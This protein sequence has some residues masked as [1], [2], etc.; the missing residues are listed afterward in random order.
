MSLGI[1]GTEMHGA[2]P[3]LHPLRILQK[4]NV[5]KKCYFCSI[6]GNHYWITSRDQTLQKKKSEILIII[7][8]T[9]MN[10]VRKLSNTATFVVHDSHSLVNSTRFTLCIITSRSTLHIVNF[11]VN[12]ARLFTLL[13]QQHTLHTRNSKFTLHIRLQPSLQFKLHASYFIV[14]TS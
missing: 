7:A 11:L 12:S 10:E 4:V 13:T 14:H 3:K 9:S 1:N 5:K 2:L 6:L 8:Y